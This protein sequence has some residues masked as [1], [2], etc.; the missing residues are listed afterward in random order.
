MGKGG[1]YCDAI[2]REHPP[3]SP[4]PGTLNHRHH[5]H[6]TLTHTTGQPRSKA[7]AH[8]TTKVLA[9]LHQPKPGHTIH[10]LVTP[11]NRFR[12]IA[13]GQIN[14]EIVQKNHIY[15]AEDILILQEARNSKEFFIGRITRVIESRYSD[16]ISPNWCVLCLDA[17]AYMNC[18]K[19]P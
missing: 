6:M 5:I 2:A 18:K 12:A 14:F 10:Y 1:R 17:I 19:T 7:I 4:S 9:Q 3:P 11:P 8:K 15:R 16:G 13:K